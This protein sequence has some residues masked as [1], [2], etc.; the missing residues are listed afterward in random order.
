MSPIRALFFLLLD[1]ADLLQMTTKT[2]NIAVI[3]PDAIARTKI[4]HPVL[5]CYG[6]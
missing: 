3:P 2:H 6:V 5:S 4:I 1:E